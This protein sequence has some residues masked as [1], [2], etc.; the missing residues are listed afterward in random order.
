MLNQHVSNTETKNMMQLI[1][2]FR[3]LPTNNVHFIF[4]IYLYFVIF[5]KLNY[6]DFWIFL[7]FPTANGFHSFLYD[8]K[9][10]TVLMKSQLHYEQ[11]LKNNLNKCSCCVIK[12]RIQ[13]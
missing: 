12:N 8:V 3:S 10:V 2:F 11:I 13:G 1:G 4:L 5:L 9:C 6:A 7:S